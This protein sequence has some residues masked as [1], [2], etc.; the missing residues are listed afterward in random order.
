MQS[1]HRNPFDGHP[2]WSGDPAVVAVNGTRDA[3]A[4]TAKNGAT[5]VSLLA[6]RNL[7]RSFGT[8]AGATVCLRGVSLA[9][10]RGHVTMLTGP[11]G[12][13]KTTLLGILSGLL[14][15][16]SGQVIALGRDLWNVSA[17]E[18]E[19]FHLRHCGFVF[20]GCNL[21][22]TLTAWQ[23]LE[24]VLCWGLGLSQAEARPR[25]FEMLELLDL[26]D[27]AQ[28]TPEELSGGEKQRVAIGRALIKQPA[29]CFADEPTSALD[30]EHGEQ[31]IR[32]MCQIARD[33]GTT[34]L[35][36]GHDPRLT[37][38]ADRVIHLCDGRL[39]EETAEFPA[40]EVRP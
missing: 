10:Y 12:S 29:F 20:Q 15:P 3:A 4:L 17:A 30:W 19:D 35:M 7:K 18:R 28:L 21:F 8:G 22:P 39:I 14:A 2:L 1:P 38:F 9:L 34:V 23:Q 27:K 5:G 16:D 40:C 26:A 13:G 32:L 37:P 24:M 11:S 33:R 31:A 36:V 25:L 6:G